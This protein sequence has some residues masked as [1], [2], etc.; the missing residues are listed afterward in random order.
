MRPWDPGLALKSDA[1]WVRTQSAA[2]RSSTGGNLEAATGDVSRLRLAL[3]GARGIAAG[4]VATITPSLELGLRLDGGDAETG[5]GVE[6]GFGLQYSAPARG[7]TVE[8]RVRGLL[9]HSDS[10]FK[11]WG[12]SGLVRL[13]P[14]ISGRG[15]SFSVAPVWGAALG[16]VQRLWSEGLTQDLAP[17][18]AFEAEAGL[19]AELGYGLRPPV[20]RGVLT[21]Y[22]GFSTAGDGDERNWRIG[23]RWNARPAF[24][25]AFETSLGDEDGDAQSPVAT[26]SA[27]YRW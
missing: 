5:T 18:D 12:A 10:G 22:A 2:A 7:L 24:G 1:L 13:D 17:D 25:L 3:E 6:A 21:P 16:G 23:A 4:S 26:L 11:E 9:T 14:G 15:L 20:G 27:E 8:G 19:Q